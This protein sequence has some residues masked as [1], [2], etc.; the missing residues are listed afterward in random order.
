M[1]IMSNKVTQALVGGVVIGLLVG[2]AGTWL[3]LDQG[4]FFADDGERAENRRVE[5]AAGGKAPPPRRADTGDVAAGASV[6][7][8]RAATQ[9]AGNTV[10]L[11]SVTIE[12][13]GWAVVYESRSGQPGNALGAARL[14][15]GSYER[16]SVPLLR[17]TIPGQTYFAVLHRDDGDKAF[18]LRDDFPLRDEGGTPIMVSFETLSGESGEASQ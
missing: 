7:F 18:E 3:Y 6:S 5:D 10:L 2:A 12:T 17:G 1:S 15:A 13:L 9:E 14:D 11:T 8:L 4:A 16:V